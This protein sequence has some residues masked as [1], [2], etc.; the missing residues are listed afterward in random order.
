[1]DSGRISLCESFDKGLS[2][3][4]RGRWRDVGPEER[5]VMVSTRTNRSGETLLRNSAVRGREFDWKAPS[6]SNLGGSV[7]SLCPVLNCEEGDRRCD[8]CRLGRF[9]TINSTSRSGFS[10]LE[11]HMLQDIDQALWGEEMMLLC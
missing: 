10:M 1:M 8:A 4:E 11:K 3:N 2:S 7:E 9:G 5:G 6:G